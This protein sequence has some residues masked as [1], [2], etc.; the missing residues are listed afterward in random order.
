MAESKRK[1]VNIGEFIDLVLKHEGLA[2]GQTPFRIT[3]PSMKKWTSMFDDTIKVKLNPQAAKKPGTE[4]FLYTERPEDVPPAVTEQ[5]RRYN[6]KP[7][8]YA[9]PENVTIEQAVRLFD[10]SGAD[11]KIKYLRQFGVDPS[12]PLKTLFEVQALENELRT[13]MPGAAR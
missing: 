6:A 5:F 12:I 2:P 3:D 7:K 13:Q 11:G 4:N 9:L 8:K 10:Q 1:S